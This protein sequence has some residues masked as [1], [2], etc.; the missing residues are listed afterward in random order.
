MLNTENGEVVHEINDHGG[1]IEGVEFSPQSNKFVTIGKDGIARMFDSLTGKLLHSNNFRALFGGKCKFSNKGDIYILHCQIGMDAS[2]PIAYDALTGKELFKIKHGSGVNDLSFTV[3]DQ[4]ILTTSRDSTAKMWNRHDVTLPL[5]SYSNGDWVSSALVKESYPDRVFTFS[6]KGDIYVFDTESELFIDGPYRGA[7][8]CGWLSMHIVD[9]PDSKYFLAINT[10]KSVA[11]W[12]FE[13]S[14]LALN[15]TEKLVQFSSE[16]SGVTMD[17]TMALQL[18]TNVTESISVTNSPEGQMWQEWHRS[19]N[20]LN[21]PFKD[22]N[23]KKYRDFLISQNTLSS[24]EEIMYLYPMDKEVLKLY[25]TKLSDL[26]NKQN[27]ETFKRNAYKI[28]SAWY[29]SISN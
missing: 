18:A 20:F 8:D 19:G 4:K 23:P 28:S 17:K 11:L 5:H 7:E 21:S 13:L 9:K 6:R 1:W 14:K 22:R 15:E 26:S 2:T 29:E 25:A 24:L 12:P 16:I 3:D 27:I 10:S